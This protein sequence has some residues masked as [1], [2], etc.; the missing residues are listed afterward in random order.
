MFFAVQE[1][2]AQSIVATVAQRVREDIDVTA[3]RRR[4]EDLRAYDLYIQGHYLSDNWTP[5]AQ[6]RIE[7]LFEEARRIDPT[8]ARA[9][10]GLAYVHLNRSLDGG[11]WSPHEPDEHRLAALRLA[12]EALVL[13]PNDPRV[14]NT[15]GFI[16]LYLREFARAERHLNLARTMNPN[17]PT[18]QAIWGLVQGCLGEPQRGLPSVEIAFKLNPRHPTWYNSFLA[19]LL[20]QL[21]RYAEAAPCLEQ[22][23][24]P[25]APIRQLKDVAWL[26]ATYGHLARIDEARKCG[27][28]F[29]QSAS[30]HW[31]G[32][33]KAGPAEFVD[34]VVDVSF[35]QRETDIEN[36]REGLRLAGLPG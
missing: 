17:D 7:A 6:K 9:Y 25:T 4:P 26:A 13:D 19:K 23:N 16:C 18:I 15:L 32:D 11:M 29:V 24:Y 33:P 8:F 21:G 10:T 14:H 5:E 27:R 35:L 12:E 20:F 28:L 36:L 3:R 34:W 30:S 31:L 1:E 22:P 2:I